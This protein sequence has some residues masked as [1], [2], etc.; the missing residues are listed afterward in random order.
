MTL[1]LKDI[2][3]GMRDSG[4]KALVPFFT[5]GYPDDATFLALVWAAAGAGCRLIEIG[6]P[7]S[8]PIADGPVI[9]ASSEHALAGGT[10]LS[11]VLDLAGEALRDTG[12][13]LV[14]MGYV[15]PILRMG[16]EKFAERASKAGVCGAIVPD[17]PFEESGEVRRILTD[18]G[19][20]LVDLVALT[21]PADRI[22]AIASVADG[23]IYLVALTGV[24]GSKN[25]RFSE[26]GDFTARVRRETDL[27][28]YAGFG[29]SDR[30]QARE[31]AGHADGVI[32]GSALI[33]IIQEAGTG[34]KA[35]AYVGKFLKDIHRAINPTLRSRTA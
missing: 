28:L 30:D 11:R 2:A 6:I 20:T 5:A 24:T 26:L 16:L 17:V 13:G 25:S 12:S 14:L 32:I 34:E 1:D 15:N 8:D 9:Q 4:E 35:I 27:P 22:G 3:A 19:I 31:A 7:F 23:F 29:I 21:S 10:T 18:H 33:R